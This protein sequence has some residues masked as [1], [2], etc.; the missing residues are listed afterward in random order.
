LVFFGGGNQSGPQGC[1]YDILAIYLGVC[2]QD[3]K[4]YVGIERVDGRKVGVID[5]EN[6]F[7]PQN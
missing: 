3:R 5:V 6:H 2:D 4:V 7:D 1:V